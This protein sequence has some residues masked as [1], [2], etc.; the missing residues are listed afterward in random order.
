L[1]R[2]DLEGEVFGFLGPNGAGKSTTT[3]LLLDLI[4]PSTGSAPVLGLAACRETVEIRR[5]V[6]FL[7]DLAL[8]PKLTGRVVLG[9]LMQLRSGVDPRVRSTSSLASLSDIRQMR[10]GHGH[11]PTH[12]RDSVS[13]LSWHKL[14]VI[15]SSLVAFVF[16]VGAAGTVPAGAATPKSLTWGITS[17]DPSLDPGLVYAIDP[18]IITSAMCNSLLQ[19]GPQGQLEPELAA[20]W[21]QTSP[22]S[23]VYNL[24][25]NARFWDGNPVT[26]ADVAFSVNRI[27]SPKLASPLLSLLQTGNIKH[28]V[29]SGKWQ[30]TIDLTSPNPIAQDL[31]A[32]PV[33]QVVEQSVAQKWGS[34]FGSTPS[35]AMCS[36]PFR[37]VRYVKGSV[38]VL[39]AVPN[40]WDSSA[41]PQIASITFQEVNDAEALI[42]GLRS[43][44]INGTYDLPARDASTLSSDSSLKVAMVPYGGDINYLSPNVMKGPFANAL[45]RRAFNLAVPRSALASA[46]DGTNGRPLRD[47][48][49]PA[50]FT[51]NPAAYMAAYNALPN[52]VTPNLAAAKKLIA[53]AHAQGESVTIGVENSLTSDTVSAAL[54]QIGSSIGLD[55]K[56]DKLTPAAFG[57]ISY[58]ATCPRPVDALLNWW[59]PDFPAPSAEV[60]PPLASN[61]SDVSC[62]FSKSFDALRKQWAATSNGTVAQANATIAMIKKLTADDVYVPL[63]SDPLVMVQPSNLTGYTQTQVFVY[64]DFPD[65]VHF[66]S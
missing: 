40:Y 20:S 64:Q 31:P 7:R 51:E 27:A 21:K 1:F 9:Y 46:V 66:T 30:V 24:V 54:Q 53:Q 52:P 48:E 61:F 45:V 62:Y 10:L 26:A 35:K 56:I 37:P 38:T 49:T 58:S 13:H 12:R 47:I 39:D 4:R 18:N 17:D 57:N 22:T 34:A 41:Q 11:R 55:V 36:G 43:G 32:T 3:R 33:G 8:Y 6:G 29:V 63:Y 23:Y 25:H 60:V 2:L 14:G 44:A 65:Q 59:N 28:A 19:F 16:L 50:L 15:V 42:A 5:R